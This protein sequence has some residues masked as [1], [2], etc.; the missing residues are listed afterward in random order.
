[1]FI[2]PVI[3]LTVVITEEY[4]C[5]QLIQNFIQY[6]SLKVNAIIDEITEDHQCRF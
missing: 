6:S 2:Y 4:L 5:Y 1:M 3:K